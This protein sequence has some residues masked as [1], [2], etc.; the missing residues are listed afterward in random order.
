MND[1]GELWAFVRRHPFIPERTLRDLY[2][3]RIYESMLQ[4]SNPWLKKVEVKGI[5][6]CY[7]EKREPMNS[8]LDLRRAETARRYALSVMGRGAVFSSMAPGFEADGE[9][10]WK[11]HWWRIWVDPGGCAPEALRFIQS[12]P[13][14]FGNEVHDLILT[15]HAGR[16]ES[17]A[18]QVERTWGGGKKVYVM[19]T[20]G[21]LHRIAR[22]RG[23]SRYT[24]TW[25][26][27]GRKDV[28]AH[29]R[30][31]QRRSHK[32][33]LMAGVAKDIDDL[34]L[35]LLIEAGNLPLLTRYELAYVQTD[36]AT[37]MREIIERL[38][39]LEKMGLLETAK[40]PVVRDRLEKRK[41]LTSLA[42]EILAAHWGTTVTNMM[43]MHPWPQVVDKKNKRPIYGLKWLRTFGKHYD[44]VRKFT[45]AL[46][47]GGRGV[48]N[49]IG[50]VETCVV[51]T[52]GSR[53]LYRDHRRRGA[54]K[55]TGV[56]KPDALIWTRI[57]Q[58]GWMDGAASA[59]KPVCEHTLWLEADRG[60]IPL[61]RLA[62]KLDG[63][64]A[65]WESVQPMKP[66]LIWVIEGTP[67]REANILDM[68]KERG[69]DG[70]TVLMERLVLEEGHNWWT[71]HVP[72][73]MDMSRLKVGLK[74]DAIGGMA[75]WREIWNTPDGRGET[76]LLGAQPWQKRVI[77]RSPPRKGEQVW[78]RHKV[79]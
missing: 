45:L 5:G 34:D 22:P 71:T 59:H 50:E 73:S 15:K 66:M 20:D 62:T 36:D 10:Y 28:D 39:A 13:K 17:L 54:E 79:D 6:C 70:W 53:L 41:V 23:Y 1:R 11:A 60:T 37:R 9:F 58:R 24:K 30:Q 8:L 77:K 48:S 16:M 55:Q 33:S 46:V 40:S 51:T 12:P 21:E 52:I 25:K 64:A 63:Y 47:Y 42:L 7:A 43:R 49:Q 56:V 32:R 72:V 2:G 65:I 18:R 35:E 76:P 44:M 74:V 78:L 57:S 19:H 38:D 3:E 4:E 31:R 29:I 61:N 75:P 26:P 27:Y 67:A 68:M 14:E 69:I